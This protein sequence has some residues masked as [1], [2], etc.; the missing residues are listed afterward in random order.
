MTLE[1]ILN[2]K[3]TISKTHNKKGVYCSDKII[4]K[5]IN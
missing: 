2:V 1:A 5:E 4:W 3:S